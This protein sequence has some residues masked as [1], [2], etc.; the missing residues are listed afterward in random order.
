MAEKPPAME[1]VHL[2]RPELPLVIYG[3]SRGWRGV[4]DNSAQTAYSNI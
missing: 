2:L 1:L 3:K 4:R